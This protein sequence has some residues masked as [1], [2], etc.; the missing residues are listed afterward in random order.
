[1]WAG[2]Y[3]LIGMWNRSLRGLPLSSPDRYGGG[4]SDGEQVP[5]S[6]QGRI[7]GVEQITGSF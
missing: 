6:F 7:C 1:M 3:F 2:S 4:I 5:G